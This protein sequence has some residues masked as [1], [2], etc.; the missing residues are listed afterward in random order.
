MGVGM[1][2]ISTLASWKTDGLIFPLNTANGKRNRAEQQSSADSRKQRHLSLLLLLLLWCCCLAIIGQWMRHLAWNDDHHEF[3]F[4]TLSLLL[5]LLLLFCFCLICVL[6]CQKHLSINLNTKKCSILCGWAAKCACKKE[7]YLN[8]VQQEKKGTWGRERG[9]ADWVCEIFGN[10][11]KLQ[12]ISINVCQLP[13]NY[14]LL[15]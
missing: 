14:S 8:W 10:D 1:V 15:K 6:M 3:S 11:R 7:I 2:N 13:K 5:L 9:C 12:S 4:F